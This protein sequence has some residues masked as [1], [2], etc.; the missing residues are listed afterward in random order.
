MV[1]KLLK[2]CGSMFTQPFHGLGLGNVGISGQVT[3]F[4]EN[5][6]AVET[7]TGRHCD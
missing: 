6:A 5:G 4:P 3:F 1:R 2:T 7:K